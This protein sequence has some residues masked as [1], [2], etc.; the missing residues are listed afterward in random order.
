MGL[1]SDLE[2]KTGDS[3]FGVLFLDPL[4]LL[5]EAPFGFGEAP[6]AVLE[7]ATLSFRVLAE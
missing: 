2:A 7:E 1:L 5:L 3:G 6:L 4:L